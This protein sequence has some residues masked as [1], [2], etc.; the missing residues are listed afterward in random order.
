MNADPCTNNT[1][2]DQLWR[3]PYSSTTQY[4]CD[5]TLTA[6]W[7]RFMM[8]GTSAQMPFSVTQAIQV[9]GTLAPSWFYGERLYFGVDLL[10]L[11]VVFVVSFITKEISIKLQNDLGRSCPKVEESN[12]MLPSKAWIAVKVLDRQGGRYTL[13]RT[14]LVLPGGVVV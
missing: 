3:Y 5:S 9:C 6:G 2:I 11:S 7:Y 12:K 10:S 1:T 14:A 13:Y 4:H 8:N